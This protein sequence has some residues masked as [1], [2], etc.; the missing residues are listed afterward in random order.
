MSCPPIR[1]R[2][3]T[4]R[5]QSSDPYPALDN[6]TL[7]IPG[8]QFVA[9]LGASGSGKSTFFN[10]IAGLDRPTAGSV[11]IGAAEVTTLS[12]PA[13]TKWRGE[14][15]GLV[16]Q[17]YQLFPTLTAVENVIAPMEFVGRVPVS[18][19]FGRATELLTQLELADHLHKRP[20]QLSGGQQQRVA[21]ARALANDPPIVLADEPTGS[22]DT[23]SGAVVLDTLRTIADGRRTVIII[24]HD[25]AAAARADRIIRFTDG[26]AGVEIEPEESQV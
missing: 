3:L 19:R 5:Y 25:Q 9:I 24:T 7:E 2:G 17:S 1:T 18:E 11:A 14:S 13:L 20:E 26:K 21:I 6:V 22:L 10:L 12:G 4:R 8:G 23:T 15:I 16:F